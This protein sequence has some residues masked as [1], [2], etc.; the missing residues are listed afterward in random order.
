VT[1]GQ[2]LFQWPVTSGQWPVKSI[3]LPLKLS[4][5]PNYSLL[6]TDH[7]PLA[8]GHY[9]STSASGKIVRISKIEIIGRK[10]MNRNN[11][12]KK[13]P[14]VPINIVQSHIDG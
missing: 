6:I 8:T 7:W 13:N 2:Y 14:S 4:Q 3:L 1:S 11:S 9:S 10:R 5:T 12:V